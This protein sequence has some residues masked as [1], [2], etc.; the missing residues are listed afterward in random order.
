MLGFLMSSAASAL[1]DVKVNL[2][3]DKTSATLEDTIVLE[4]A[5]EGD[6]GSRP[7][8]ANADDFDVQSAGASSQIQI[9]DGQISSSK[10]YTF[11]L[12]PKKQGTFTVG[13]AQVEIDG[14]TYESGTVTITVSGAAVHAGGQEAFVEVEASNK[15][16]YVGEQVVYTIRFYTQ[17]SVQNVQLK[18]ME[19]EGFFKESLGD[20][21]SYQR[22]IDGRPWQVSEVRWALYPMSPG[23]VSIPAPK[24][25]AQ[26][27]LPSRSRSFF[28]DPF[29]DMDHFFRRPQQRTLA[30]EAATLDV[31]SPPQE[32]KP[33]GFA[34]LVGN[35]QIALEAKDS[36]VEA[37]QSTTV[38]VTVKGDG[39]LRGLSDLHWS[40][41]EGVKAYDDQPTLTKNPS[42]NGL[43]QAKTFRKAV[44]PLKEG[45]ITLP[46]VAL[47]YFDPKI[48]E[49]RTLETQPIPLKVTP[50]SRPEDLKAVTPETQAS[51]FAEERFRSFFLSPA[52][53]RTALGLVSAAIIFFIVRKLVRKR[54]LLLE[55]DPGY[56]RRKRALKSALRSL[57]MLSAK[58]DRFFYED[59]SL[60][61][62][63][64]L[65]DKF[66]IDG[67]ALTPADIKRRLAPAGVSEE[68]LERV[69]TFLRECDEGL[70]GG[71][72]VDEDQRK[73]LSGRLEEMVRDL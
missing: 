33:A 30:G 32:G 5:V 20:S 66:G 70:Y 57:K 44:V 69:V 34:G 16:P 72:A 31:K 3:A 51:P 39:D 47:S 40:L 23:T 37:G 45:E 50:S 22:V 42:P 62:R 53:R 1:A 4:V 10:S 14:R 46:P 61:L 36:E 65:G 7:V 27:L 68:K 29:F 28:D 52:V 24:V 6:D 8:L 71:R 19:F 9:A 11:A 56:K 13:P 48:G 67:R 49:Y 54:R 18:P 64:F 38:T 55:K 41:P 58:S 17:A 35:F 12:S 21:K 2:T 15:A 73:E 43:V 63:D 25:V 59:A 26:F 60:L